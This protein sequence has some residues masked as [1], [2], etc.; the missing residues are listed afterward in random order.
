MINVT[1]LVICYATREANGSM[2]EDFV[3]L[4]GLHNSADVVLSEPSTFFTQRIPP[5]FTP[6]RTGVG[7]EQIIDMMDTEAGDMVAWR[8][9]SDQKVLDLEAV[10]Q[11]GP[12]VVAVD[13][14]WPTPSRLVQ[15]VDST[16]YG[17][18]ETG[19]TDGCDMIQGGALLNKTAEYTLS[20][21]W[22]V[23]LTDTLVNGTYIMCFRPFGGVY[24][25]VIK[26]TLPHHQSCHQMEEMA[27]VFGSYDMCRQRLYIVPKPVFAPRIL[28]AGS[29]L[30]LQ[31][32]AI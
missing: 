21:P 27:D 23:T 19:R 25:Q 11:Y 6:K 15:G 32:T 17:G 20:S 31:S 3:K 28:V 24:T 18:N 30:Q 29:V 7:H 13:S 5:D 10:A 26:R 1:D 22:R 12:D 14:R 8:H 9:Y 2:A 4:T 16:E